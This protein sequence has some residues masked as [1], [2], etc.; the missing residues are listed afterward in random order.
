MLI[1]LMGILGKVKSI[2][3][4]NERKRYMDLSKHLEYDALEFIHILCVMV[5]LDVYH[6]IHY[7]IR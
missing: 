6:N 4:I 1:P 7:I 5:L 2:W 3:Y